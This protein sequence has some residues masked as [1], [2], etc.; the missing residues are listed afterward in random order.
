[1]VFIVGVTYDLAITLTFYG[2]KDI[3]LYF[4]K[5]I[6]NQQ[7]GCVNNNNEKC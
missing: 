2:Y 6:L 5:E 3:I 7:Y 4:R 1:M